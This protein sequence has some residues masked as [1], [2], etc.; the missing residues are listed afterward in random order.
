MTRA[1]DLRASRDLVGDAVGL[2]ARLATDGYVFVRQLLD[3]G[4]VASIGRSALRHLQD[5]R[6]TEA[7]PD[8]V[9][10]R[11][12]APVKAIRMLHA[13]ADTGYR[14]ILA[15]AEFNK[16]PFVDPLPT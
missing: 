14:R 8:P 12:L 10:A 3:P 11:P 5:A 6:W 1:T 9:S 13:F 16:I 4:L 7:G 2:R 15:D